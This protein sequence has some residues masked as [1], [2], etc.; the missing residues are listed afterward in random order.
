MMGVRGGKAAQ[1][2][3]SQAH[4]HCGQGELTPA[5]KLWEQG[6]RGCTAS[7]PGGCTGISR[8]PKLRVLMLVGLG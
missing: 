1:K 5:G 4:C 7:P 8:A 6:R 3:C 2:E